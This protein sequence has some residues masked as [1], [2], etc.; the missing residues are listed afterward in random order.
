MLGALIGLL[1]LVGLVG[2]GG[3]N[4]S[5]LLAAAPEN[6]RDAGTAKFSLASSVDSQALPN[7]SASFTGD[8]E[9]SF[10][11]QKMRMSMDMG[12]L[13]GQSQN[14]GSVELVLDDTTMYMRLGGLS[15]QLPG[16][17]E[18][19]TVELQK[20]GEQVGANFGQ[21]LQGGQSDPGAFL[22][23]LR[24]AADD[25]EKV[26]SEQVRGVATTHYTA[27]VNLD[28]ALEELP[29]DQGKGLRQML[30]RAN[31][32]DS[33]P[34][35]VWIGDEGLARRVKFTIEMSPPGTQQQMS[36]TQTLEFFDYGTEID[37][38]PPPEDNTVNL[39]QL[40]GAGSPSGG[41]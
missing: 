39:Q 22:E 30:E 33:Y 3:Q 2:C 7:G 8:G 34:V 24:G 5:A 10:T 29:E 19:V 35:D 40:Q 13:G 21:L 32:P 4:P 28:D 36:Q 31:V 6:A 1:G 25:V 23:T 20:L 27:T 41:A 38:S 26:G 9:V 37:V 11:E 12:S 14:L 15:Q 16:G 18:W 17:A